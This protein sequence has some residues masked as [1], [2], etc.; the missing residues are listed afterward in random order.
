MSDEKSVREKLTHKRLTGPWKRS[1]EIQRK[2]RD[3]YGDFATQ[4]VWWREKKEIQDAR[5]W[6]LKYA[7]VESLAERHVIL[8]QPNRVWGAVRLHG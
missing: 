4:M 8:G 7:W 5:S 3:S 1:P 6:Y 2:S